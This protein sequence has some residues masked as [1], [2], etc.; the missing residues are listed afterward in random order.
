MEE[1]VSREQKKY[2]KAHRDEQHESSMWKHSVEHH[3]GAKQGYTFN[4][5]RTFKTD[6]SRQI[7]EVVMI[8]S[9]DPDNTLNS[10]EGWHQGYTPHLVLED[11]DLQDQSRGEAEKI[12]IGSN[13]VED[14]EHL[15]R[16]MRRKKG[17]SGITSNLTLKPKKHR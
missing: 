3:G 9:S 14:N 1:Q 15:P 11:R 5:L 4:M 17:G 7:T 10:K 12:N 16:A 2:L 8:Q 13:G 6:L